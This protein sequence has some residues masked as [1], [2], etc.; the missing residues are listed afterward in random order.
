[1]LKLYPAW[2]SVRIADQVMQGRRLHSSPCGSCGGGTAGAPQRHS[3]MAAV[4]RIRHS[5]HER[6]MLTAYA[7]RK[8]DE[9]SNVQPCFDRA[10]SFPVVTSQHIQSAPLIK[11][12][13]IERTPLLRRM[14]CYVECAMR[15]RSQAESGRDRL[16]GSRFTSRRMPSMR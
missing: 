15:L 2:V 12:S 1:M 10:Q 9:L 3:A 8:I 16:N 14:H 13:A 4:G 5:S 7:A 6:K 11:T